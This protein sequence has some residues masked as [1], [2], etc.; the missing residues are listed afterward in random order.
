MC[1]IDEES[2]DYAR[3]MLYWLTYSTRTLRLVEVAEIVAIDARG[4][5]RFNPENRYFDSKEIL[6]ICPSLVSVFEEKYRHIPGWAFDTDYDVPYIKLAHFSV[7]EYLISVDIQKGPAS[8]YA[9]SRELADTSIGEACL[10]LLLHFN[11]S[12]SLVSQLEER[13]T[14]T[15]E[16]RG[17]GLMSV[18]PAKQESRLLLFE[19]DFPLAQYAAD[20][21]FKHAHNVSPG[22][23]FIEAL[24][25]KM[26]LKRD[27]LENWARLYERDRS[28]PGSEPD[29]FKPSNDIATAVYY[30]SETGFQEPLKMLI[31][32]GANIIE[33]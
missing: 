31:A 26:F 8:M 27:T 20:N 30:A 1:G 4:K 24:V 16:S 5:P 9:I 15:S 33:P 12:D 10:A 17:N 22:N 32:A 23:D 18:E 2:R 29:L 13:G 6:E 19:R 25:S 21:W 14:F 28:W 3:E 11:K 7:K